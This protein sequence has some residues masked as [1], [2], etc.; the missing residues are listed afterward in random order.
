MSTPCGAARPKMASGDTPLFVLLL[1]IDV[2][3][4]F[5]GEEG[6]L[7]RKPCFQKVGRGMRAHEVGSLG[8][9]NTIAQTLTT[10]C[11]HRI[12]A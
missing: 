3:R 8:K 12:V 7:A 9:R 10:K 5:F 1:E 11:L 2:G 4:A 6:D